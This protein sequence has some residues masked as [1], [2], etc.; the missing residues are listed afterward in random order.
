MK[1]KGF[2]F[3]AITLLA[4]AAIPAAVHAQSYFIDWYTI[5]GGGGTS[6]GGVYS[7]SGT[8]GRPDA[9]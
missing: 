9:G 4:C 6:T 2:R 1:T 5:D 7:V 3:L 8:I